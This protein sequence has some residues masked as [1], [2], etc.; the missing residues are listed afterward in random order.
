RHAT[1]RGPAGAGDA[2]RQK[3]E[4]V[5]AGRAVNVDCSLQARTAAGCS[6]VASGLAHVA[7]NRV[8]SRLAHPMLKRITMGCFM[9]VVTVVLAV[10]FFAASWGL[11]VLC[12]R[13]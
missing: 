8:S 6:S 4:Y 10:A 1:G 2:R 5:R 11:V 3:G 12:D 13:L 9:G 7:E